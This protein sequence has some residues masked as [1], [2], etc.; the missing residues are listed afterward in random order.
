M[1]ILLV[2]NCLTEIVRIDR[3]LLAGRHDVREVYAQSAPSA[4]R[5][6]VGA[7]AWADVVLCWFAS[8]HS[9]LPAIL[10]KVLT[11]PLV[12]IVGGYDTANLRDIGYGHQRGGIRRL[13][14]SGIIRGASHLIV[15][16]HYSE[17]ELAGIL[18]VRQKQISVLYH[19]V[20]DTGI[21]DFKA[22][23]N[24]RVITVGNVNRETALRK[25]IRWV[26]EAAAFL[27]G[28]EIVIA[29]KCTDDALEYLKSIS[30]PNVR[31]TGYLTWPALR[32]LYESASVYVQP[33]A[34]EAFGLSVAEAML[35]GCIPVVSKTTALP[36]VVGNCGRLLDGCDPRCIA[37]I[38]SAQQ[39]TAGERLRARERVLA[40]FSLAQR[41]CGLNHALECAVVDYARGGAA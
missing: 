24:H 13:V 22:K 3:D 39:A 34:H 19:G 2:H 28:T 16:S 40:K 9:I 15:N 12:M 14:S 1:K 5:S 36:E 7:A 30:S 38:R 8:W 6:V 37:A 25:G 18:G 29:G 10:A 41:E 4:I 17:G 27:P 32:R 11:K 31:F 21:S 23:L 20:P 26:C 35:A 33:S